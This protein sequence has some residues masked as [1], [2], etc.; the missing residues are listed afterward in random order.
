VADYGRPSLSE[1]AS[2]ARLAL[3][4]RVGGVEASP[5]ANAWREAIRA[6]TLVATLTNAVLAL[7]GTAAMVWVS[8]RLPW[9][10]A[11]VP[12]ATLGTWRTAA[13]LLGFAW[14]PAY[15][16]LVLGHRRIAQAVAGL[17]VIPHL[18]ILAVGQVVDDVS[19]P[20]GMVW[21]WGLLNFVL[22]FAMGACD[23][24]VASLRTWLLALPIGV[25]VV[26]LPVIIVEFTGPPLVAGDLSGLFCVLVVA[27][28]VANL[29]AQISRRAGRALPWSLAL[30]L[31]AAGALI[32]RLSALAD[33]NDQVDAHALV[34]SAVVEIVAV[35]VLAAP[36]AA[37]AV[38]ALRRL[39]PA[40]DGPES[41]QTAT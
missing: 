17:A 2:V 39:S 7:G 37:L 18:F 26:P 5:R 27:A 21:A 25:L 12:V 28:M 35:L 16:A 15:L 10:P 6:A 32:L 41:P 36:T 4:L 29:I 14:V 23:D 9:L 11:A 8:G 19:A 30:T 31:L 13:A 24:R 40:A 3:R 33:L 38:R 20:S 34:T 1:V 22:L